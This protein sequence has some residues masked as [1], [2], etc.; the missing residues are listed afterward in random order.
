MQKKGLG[1]LRRQISPAKGGE[2]GKGPS[3]LENTG[4]TTNQEKKCD[5][6]IQRSQSFSAVKRATQMRSRTMS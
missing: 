1:V 5:G 6:K 2:R 4:F 3:A